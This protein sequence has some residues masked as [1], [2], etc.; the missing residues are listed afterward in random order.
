M[1]SSAR[2][3]RRAVICA[4]GTGALAGAMLFGA[5][6]TATP[7]PPASSTAVHGRRAGARDVRRHVRHVELPNRPPQRERLLH[8][9]QRPTQ[10][11]D[12]RSGTDLSRR[13]SAGSGRAS[14]HPATLG[15]LPRTLWGSGDPLTVSAARFVAQGRSVVGASVDGIACAPTDLVGP[16]VFALLGWGITLSPR[17]RRGAVRRGLGGLAT[18]LRAQTEA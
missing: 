5:A 3:A 12:Q 6:A 15:R 18:Q 8:Q 13:Q 4:I 16:K 9:P 1:L 11:S 14:G 17:L 7:G 10:G 2:P